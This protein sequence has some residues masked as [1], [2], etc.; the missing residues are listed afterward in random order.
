M[1]RT[2]SS[3]LRGA[4]LFLS[5]LA[6][7]SL[8]AVNV[9][10]STVQV[11]DTVTL[12][13]DVNFF[14]TGDSP[15]GT[16][17]G[18]V[19]I[20][21]TDHAVL[22][23][24]KVKPSVAIRL[25]SH[26]KIN[27]QAAVNNT[28]CQVKMYNIGSI[29][30][31]YGN[32]TKPL[33]VYSEQNFEG[34][35]CND[36]GLEHT[37]GYMNTLTDAKL[38]NKIRSFKLKRGY[39]VTFS[40]LAG[41][42]GYSRCFIASNKDLEIAE[43]PAV[44]DKKISSYRVFKWYD[45]GKKQLANDLTASTLAALNVQSSYTW[46]Q[47][48]DMGPDYECVPNHIYED[49]PS[50]SAIGSATWSPHTKNNNEPLNKSDDTPQD[51]KTI[52][53]NWENMMR[54]GMRLCTPA[55]WDGSDYVGNAGGFL[56]EFL[57]SI[58]A[59]GW[60]C[61]IIDLHCYWA[62]GTF[63]QIHNWSDKYKR[64]IWISEWCWGASW[65]KNGA[66]ADGVTED[67]VKSALQRICSKL[68]GYNY[69][70]RYYYWNGERDPSRL[71]KNSA[72]TPAGEYYA[73]MNSGLGYNGLYDFVP[74]TPKQYGFSNFSKTIANGK[75]T[76]KWHDSNGEFNQVMQVQKRDENANWVVVADVEQKEQAADYTYVIDDPDASVDYRLY[77]V[78]VNG[79]VYTTSDE[80]AVGEAIDMN[81]T[82]MYAGENVVMNGDF[83]LGTYG[84]QDGTGATPAAP[85][86]QV[87][88]NG[89]RFG[90]S[91]LQAYGNGGNTTNQSLLTIVPIEKNADYYY[92]AT[93]NGMNATYSK[94]SLNLKGNTDETQ[95]VLQLKTSTSW[96]H[97]NATF[98][99][100]IYPYLQMSFRWMGNKAQL[101]K[102]ELRQLFATTDE[103]FADGVTKLKEKAAV[104]KL[105]N[106]TY[107]A[108]NAEIDAA[109]NSLTGD[110]KTD[111]AVMNKVLKNV[112]TVDKNMKELQKMQA[113]LKALKD[114][115]CYQ[116]DEMVA[117]AEAAAATT[118]SAEL[119]TKISELSTMMEQYL[120]FSDAAVQPQYPTLDYTVGWETVVGTYKEG[121]QRRNEKDG[122]TFW[123]AW[124][125]LSA[126]ENPT[127][128]MEIR[129][130]IT[131]IEEG[132]YT[133][134][135]NAA[136]EHYCLSDQHGYLKAGADTVVTPNLS[137]DY[138]DLP[139]GNCWETLTT[140]PVYLQDND[141]ITI[142]FVGS[143][144]GAVDGLWKQY[145]GTNAGDNR[146]GWWCATDFV[147]KYSP[148]LKRT[149]VPNEWS[150]ACLPY[151]VRPIAGVK[152]YQIAGINSEYTQLCLEPIDSVTP[153]MPFIYRSENADVV[154]YEFGTPEKTPTDAP[155]N[156][157]GFFKPSSATSRIGTGYYNLI[158]GAWEK[159]TTE[160]PY[161]T[162]ASGYIRPMDASSSNVVPVLT[163]WQ[164]ETMPINGV[165]QA[166]ID[167]N[168][169]RIRTAIDIPEIRSYAVEGV[170]TVDGR[171]LSS[172][173]ENLKSGLYIK[174]ING[175]AYK[176][177]IK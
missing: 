56:A 67:Q 158:G 3:F 171:R 35:S 160:R 30:L 173:S 117:L 172:G 175:K 20:T 31:P 39:M 155:G 97:Q 63:N 65:N 176:T 24:T 37:G 38:N 59:R 57:D 142:G 126:A 72:L 5:V 9:S 14:I 90:G 49:Y 66:F 101:D 115:K 41:G 156:I 108:F 80:K 70:E 150:V 174:V 42:R 43:L 86:F 132:I 48:H 121:D 110:N 152:L 62:E 11:T 100:G 168:N 147:L 146:E 68:N 29:I 162:K 136:T 33:T 6:S 149:V 16:S 164:G 77:M 12:D 13:T 154:F 8:S 144:N 137:Y 99:A 83:D 94:V 167:K 133:L 92:S 128:T 140:A 54:T 53:G 46:S 28:N 157:R 93:T 106:T 10:K 96:L 139:V 73:N 87:V 177:I 169:E 130:T 118:S 112:L 34:E 143:K 153:G 58:D 45:A 26:V 81:G 145:N 60:R 4:L 76:L 51:L 161:I 165:T 47:G 78:D 1:K 85:Y 91:Y 61:D 88:S 151:Q 141:S 125:S 69:V 52:L 134:A 84:W 114:V 116:Y 120:E 19:N 71:Y 89:G 18:V 104:I 138:Y 127:A 22:I 102:V 135:C 131:G 119:S 122:K 74:T 109:L 148:V 75:V 21:N 82:T 15:F 105:L 129:Q 159:V 23:L 124:W 64:P 123:N 55:S 32:N 25:L 17:N 163:D 95:V 113:N 107:P 79:K 36:F 170:Y 98:N 166:E 111:Y 103:A 44:M 27:G 50:S 7:Q 40:L 2:F